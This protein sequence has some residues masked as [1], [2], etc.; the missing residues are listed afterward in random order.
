LSPKEVLVAHIALEREELGR[1]LEDVR[2]RATANVDV[3]RWVRERP[4][5]WLAG[6]LLLGFWL[7]ARR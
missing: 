4:S 6:A 7:G 3:S 5:A 1:V 2:E